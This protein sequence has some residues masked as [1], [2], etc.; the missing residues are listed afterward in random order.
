MG[1]NPKKYHVTDEGDV[2]RIN[3]DG[4]FTSMGNAE[5]MSGTN[6]AEDTISRS[7]EP[8]AVDKPIKPFVG[9]KHRGLVVGVVISLFL[10]VGISLFYL[11][12]SH[13]RSIISGEEALY[14][15]TIPISEESLVENE[16][17]ITEEQ[18]IISME[19][20][21][22]EVTKTEP[23]QLLQPKPKEPERV[24]ENSVKPLENENYVRRA[25]DIDPNK[26][27][28]AVEVQADFP[29]GDRARS[30]WLRDNIQWPRDT[31]GQQLHGEVELDFVIE[32]DGSISNVTVTYSENPDLNT[33]AIRLISSMPKWSPAMVK[34]QPVRSPMGIT[35][36]F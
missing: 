5:K 8:S 29:G 9:K 32:R 4:S 14:A 23:Q 12:N 26:I 31:N 25:E 30:Q 22:S 16:R 28:S 33:A 34:N 36:F 15:D 24:S 1:E 27:Y 6:Q 11:L 20:S 13:K 3:E 21:I 7:T 10:L 2:Y 35:L 19:D 17:Q 18:S